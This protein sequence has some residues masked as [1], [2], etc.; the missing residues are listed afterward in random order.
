MNA[1]PIRNRRNEDSPCPHPK[2][3]VGP[4]NQGSRSGVQPYLK[5]TRQVTHGVP[6]AVDEAFPALFA[7]LGEHSVQ[8][9]GPPF[10]RTLEVDELGEPLELEVAAPVTEVMPGDEGVE[11]DVLPAGRYLTSV[12]VGPYRSATE[13]DLGEARDS[14]LR[15]AADRGLVVSVRRPRGAML[16]CCVDRF[17][18]GPA[19]TPDYSKWE[20]ELAYLIVG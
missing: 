13:T 20:T 12:H 11:A 16:P 2:P 1:V 4:P 18:V 5:M 7:W 15:F 8:P 14:L 17:R 19:D 3:L 6:A 9:S 10:I